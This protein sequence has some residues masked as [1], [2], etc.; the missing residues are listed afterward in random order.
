MIL[1]PNSL[2]MF[3]ARLGYVKVPKLRLF[4]YVINAESVHHFQHQQKEITNI[5]K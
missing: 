2:L 3:E 5:F 4:I 1:S